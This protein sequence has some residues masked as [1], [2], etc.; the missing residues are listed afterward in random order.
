MP[1]TG[2]RHVH[3]PEEIE[4]LIAESRDGGLLEPQEQV[5]LHRALRLGLRTAS[6]LMVPRERLAAIDIQTPLA[7]VLTIVTTSPFSRLPVYRGD[8]DHVAGML[9]IKDLVTEFVKGTHRRSL[10][11]LLRPIVR[12]RH[13][14]PADRLLAFLR[15]R[16]SHQALVIDVAGRVIGL[17]T[18][19]DVVAELLGGVADEFKTA[20]RRPP[21]AQPRGGA[22][23]EFAIITVLILL[24]ALFVAAEFA[25]V[26]APR[27]AIEARAAKGDR[28]A[29]RVQRVLRDTQLQD[30]YIATAQ[31]GITLASL[32]LGMYGEHVLA[33]AIYGALGR[34]GVPAWLASHGVASVI[35]VAIL[36]YFHI[37]VGE[38]VPKSL[39]LQQAERLACWI[40]PPMLWTKN[41]LYPFVVI[42]ERPRQPPAQGHRRQSPGAELGAGLHAR[43]TAADRAGERG[44]R[45]AALGVQP[46]AAGALRVRRPHRRPGHGAA[47]A[48][49]RHPGRNQAQTR[50]ARSS[51]TPPTRDIPFS[52]RTSITSSAWSTSRICFGCC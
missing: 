36:T 20:R 35:A 17:I 50:S 7:D 42:A 4:L 27:A 9:H 10:A 49:R 44:A 46:D 2:H 24:N 43:G 51:P 21:R 32:G 34:T 41:V 29:K 31:L 47:R 8:L 19:E 48:N 26:G 28:L 6:Q 25:I 3:S 52:R 1:S 11:S 40:T 39:A 5:R 22:M 15:E 45:R 18:L 14:M 38:M 33:E 37:V 13:D 12:V 23:I 16:R 30:R